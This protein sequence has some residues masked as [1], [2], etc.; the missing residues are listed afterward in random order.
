MQADNVDIA[1]LNLSSG[2]DL[3]NSVDRYL[4][5]PDE[6]RLPYAEWSEEKL[7]V[8]ELYMWASYRR[9]F[10]LAMN[11]SEHRRSR[12]GG[13]ASSAMSLDLRSAADDGDSVTRFST[14]AVAFFVAELYS[15]FADALRAAANSDAPETDEAVLRLVPAT[16]TMHYGS[17]AG[18][19]CD[20]RVMN[21]DDVQFVMDIVTR[22]LGA[23]GR[24]GVLA[25]LQLHAIKWPLAWQLLRRLD[26]LQD[27]V[28]RGQEVQVNNTLILLKRARGGTAA[29]NNTPL[30]RFHE[31]NF[32]AY[33]PVDAVNGDVLRYCVEHYILDAD[34][35]AIV[36]S[37]RASLAEAATLRELANQ[38]FADDRAYRLLA[39]Q[40]QERGDDAAERQL[41]YDLPARSNDARY[42]ARQWAAE[43]EA[44]DKQLRTMIDAGS[45]ALRHDDR[46]FVMQRLAQLD[47]DYV[48]SY[49]AKLSAFAFLTSQFA[50]NT[51]EP[52]ANHVL[53]VGEPGTGKTSFIVELAPLMSVLRLV[54]PP[55][56]DVLMK[57]ARFIVD[58][59]PDEERSEL[60]NVTIPE[61]RY[62]ATTTGGASSTSSAPNTPAAPAAAAET[63]PRRS[64]PGGGGGGGVRRIREPQKTVFENMAIVMPEQQRLVITLSRRL[65]DFSSRVSGRVLLVLPND[66]IGAHQGSTEWLFSR[67][68]YSTLG[69]ALVI[70]EAYGMRPVGDDQY[71]RALINALTGAITEFGL[72]WSTVLLGYEN[73]IDELLAV[74]EGLRSRY[75]ST[76]RLR[77]RPYNS[78][79]LT[80]ILVRAF[81]RNQSLLLVD[82]S[83]DVV[84]RS[85][86][87]LKRE[88]TQTRALDELSKHRIAER[89]YLE[90]FDAIHR[91]VAQRAQRPNSAQVRRDPLAALQALERNAF[92]AGNARS[93]NA[94]VDRLIQ[95]APLAQRVAS[96][97]GHR[98]VLTVD[99]IVRTLDS[100]EPLGE[101]P[102][103]VLK[104]MQELREQTPPPVAT[105]KPSGAGRPVK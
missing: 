64:P 25:P 79:E 72:M 75:A 32:S 33:Y 1:Q 16:V 5:P 96:P 99:D 39:E 2:G 84:R 24:Y 89:R 63:T 78:A 19:Y 44:F 36:T 95:L 102:D 38:W 50:K 22:L 77:F 29:A 67:A 86:E 37:A 103:T 69:G 35:L 83:V 31:I 18:R 43:L 48:G 3:F 56:F 97:N 28:V 21:S 47:R 54:K 98:V 90:M 68:V 20:M 34:A 9:W 104:W 92:R 91:A 66:L 23:R 88:D 4:F 15:V 41:P 61:A 60:L 10:G 49:E 93:M 59:M 11:P 94:F 80:A 55:T 46:V 73:K 53:F 14:R 13:A 105:K 100:V 87:A 76:P 81:A 57:Q 42:T 26:H 101:W 52:T 58:K 51:R 30:R 85:L 82:A 70:D 71:R 17:V 6:A 27:Y 12:G 74:N 62:G 45:S 65:R 8:F 7:Q 40:E